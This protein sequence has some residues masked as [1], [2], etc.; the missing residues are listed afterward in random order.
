[1]KCKKC[2]SQI[3]DRDNLCPNCGADMNTIMYILE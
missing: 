2:N 1:M 3:V